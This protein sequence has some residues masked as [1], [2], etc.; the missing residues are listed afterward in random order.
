LARAESK[1]RLTI[2]EIMSPDLLGASPTKVRW[3]PDGTQVYFEWRPPSLKEPATFAVPK[4]GGTPKELTKEEA[5]NVPPPEAEYTEDRRYALFI[6]GNDLCLVDASTGKKQ[7]LTRTEDR[8]TDAHFT[9][10]G[11]K[12]YFTMNNNLFLTSLEDG[13]L[14]QATNFQPAKPEAA[15]TDSQKW[16]EA[17]QKELFEA[18]REREKQKEKEKEKEKQKQKPHYLKQNQS[19]VDMRLS[20]DERLVL[21]SLRE[22]PSQAKTTIV[23]SYVTESGYTEELKPRRKVG[24]LNDKRTMSIVKQDGEVL[25]VDHRQG[26]REVRLSLV[27]WSEDGK[28]ALLL[29]LSADFKDRWFLLLDPETGKTKVIDCLHDD[30]WVKGGGHN[31]GWIPDNRNVY[32]LS[33]RDGYSH[34]YV[35]SVDGGQPKQLTRGEFE[36]SAPRISK[37]KTRWFFTS[38][39]GDPSEHHLYTMPIEGGARIRITH[40]EG[41]NDIWL[42][43]DESMLAVV[44]SYS[45][46]PP[47]LYLQ[48]NKPGAEAKQVTST[49]SEKFKAYP[50]I[51]P[52]IVTFTARDGVRV[53]AR[54]YKPED[55]KPGD[56]AVIFIHGA[57][58]MQNVHKWWSNYSREYMFNHLLMEHGYL[59]LDIDYRGSAGYGRDWRTGIYRHMGGKDLTDHVDGAKYLVDVHGVDPKRIGLYGGSYGGFMTLMAMFCAPDVFAAGAALRPVTDWAHY[60]HQ[61][62]GQ[63]LNLP[64]NDEEA[65]KRSSPI[66]F[67]EGL[68]GALLLC[69]GMVD[70]NVHFQ[71][72]VRFIQRL[73]ELRKENWEVAIYPVEDHG[74]RNE[75]SWADEY[76]RIFKLFETNLK[77]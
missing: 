45:N 39:E 2:D 64:Q 10:D 19:V 25:L 48:E 33:E 37:D 77:S 71:D 59:V 73:I 23:P 43:P 68:K 14:T 24:D 16:L 76:K 69:H 46:K 67:A 50:W 38:N 52:E 6:E 51:V 35:F 70:T 40:L 22:E 9:K 26:E 61:Y 75:T 72:T 42:S 63:I 29:G 4:E 30:A 21:F 56:P 5:E 13:S 8:K 7:R 53:R 44:R 12:V 55:F 41:R 58:Y 74:F 15:K 62:S 20:P 34:L 28:K 3:S 65:Y 66:Y 60:N 57:G 54:L 32:F 36:V 11:K 47:E 27:A 1:F 49:P 17:Q 18:L 31:A